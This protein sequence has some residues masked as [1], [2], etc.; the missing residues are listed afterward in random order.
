MTVLECAVW[1]LKTQV[2]LL[3]IFNPFHYLALLQYPMLIFHS[4][5]DGLR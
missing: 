1:A 5:S 2:F 4:A 3:D